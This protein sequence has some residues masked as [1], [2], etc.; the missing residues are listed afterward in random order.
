MT[1]SNTE[2]AEDLIVDT[3]SKPDSALPMLLRDLVR[4]A[5]AIADSLEA[6]NTRVHI[7]AAA[8]TLA[9]APAPTPTLATSPPPSSNQPTPP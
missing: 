4:S 7:A 2:R 1:Q 5:A 3:Y 9:P 8:P 6:I